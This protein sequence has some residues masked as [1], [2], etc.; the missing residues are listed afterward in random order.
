[1]ASVGGDGLLQLLC[2]TVVVDLASEEGLVKKIASDLP[3]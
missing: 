3:V 1:L 2:V